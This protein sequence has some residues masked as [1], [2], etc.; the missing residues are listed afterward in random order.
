MQSSGEVRGLNRLSLHISAVT[1]HM[2]QNPFLIFLWN[3]YVLLRTR[4]SF[5]TPP[6]KKCCTKYTHTHTHAALSKKKKCSTK[7]THTHTQLFRNSFVK[8][9]KCI[10]QAIN[11]H[12]RASQYSF[13]V[14]ATRGVQILRV[15]ITCLHLPAITVSR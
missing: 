6:K 4:S 11:S 10:S 9:K 12:Q 14:S 5:E 8:E 7:Y 15:Y 3:H 2:H 13:R 1:S